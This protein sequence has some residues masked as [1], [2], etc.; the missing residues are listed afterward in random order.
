MGAAVLDLGNFKT[1]IVR[2][3]YSYWLR[4]CGDR[5]MPRRVDIRPEE[6]RALLPFIFLVDVEGSPPTF[7]FRLVGSEIGV[8]AGK[9][10][11]GVAINEAD[12]GPQWQRIHEMYLQVAT[13]GKPQLDLYHAPWVS[14]EFWYYERFVAPLSSDGGT[15]DML[16][17][18]LHVVDREAPA[19][20][21][22]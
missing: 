2:Q 11:T 22:G 16:F 8:W 6:L 20:K 5:P 1:P 3:A 10:Y 15:V 18:S 19:K 21:G 13:S 12:Y 14:K 17:G 9:E 4:K 7:R